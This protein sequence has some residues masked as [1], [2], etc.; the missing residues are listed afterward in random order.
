MGDVADY[1]QVSSTRKVTNS[2]GKSNIRSYRNSFESSLLEE[3]IATNDPSPSPNAKQNRMNSSQGNN[4]IKNRSS[5]AL[6]KRPSF[7]NTLND[8]LMDKI[9][10]LPNDRIQGG[11][12]SNVSGKI[13]QGGF[14]PTQSP[15]LSIEA[16]HALSHA[17]VNQLERAIIEARKREM[18]GNNSNPIKNHCSS[19]VRSDDNINRRSQVSQPSQGIHQ[20]YNQ[21]NNSKSLTQSMQVKNAFTG[22]GNQSFNS[23]REYPDRPVSRGRYSGILK[24]FI[25]NYFILHYL[26]YIKLFYIELFI[27]FYFIFRNTW[28]FLFT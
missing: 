16:K 26:F 12:I 4:S 2:L 27:F 6:K 17:S 11:E 5:A 10:P 23:N 22:A 20:S 1:H 9:S 13:R 19:Q 21:A 7:D 18:N 8:P 25:L 15:R 3:P 14:T 28:K 24:C